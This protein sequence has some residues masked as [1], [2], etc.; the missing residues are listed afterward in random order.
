MLQVC[1][2]FS[3]FPILVATTRCCSYVYHNVPRE[4]NCIG[5]FCLVLMNDHFYSF[6]LGRVR[7]SNNSID[8]HFCTSTNECLIQRDGDNFSVDVSAENRPPIKF[9][10]SILLY[11]VTYGSLMRTSGRKTNKVT[12]TWILTPKR[13]KAALYRWKV[14][15]QI[16][17][18]QRMGVA[19][20]SVSQPKTKISYVSGQ[21]S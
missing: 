2:L 16:Q 5:V 1:K 14:V 15:S 10:K 6:G 18:T 8:P 11:Q 20:Y 19:L 4:T 12:V 13:L 17:G 7:L 21:T 9:A 3:S